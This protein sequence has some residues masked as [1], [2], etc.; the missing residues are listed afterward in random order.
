MIVNL[1]PHPLNLY[2]LD[3]PDRIEEGAVE[4]LF[5]VAPSGAVARIAE[6]TLGTWF[7][8]CFDH[9]VAA[10]SFTTVQVEGVEYGNITGLPPYDQEAWDLNLRPR[11]YY[12]VSLVVALAARGR[13]D[14]LVPYREV[15]NATG[16]VIGCRQLAQ[17]V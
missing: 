8:D 7:S 6:N 1:T 10:E 11:T 2:P 12:V 9:G 4:P 16:T 17:P 14:L 3:C 15:R 5:T 13:G